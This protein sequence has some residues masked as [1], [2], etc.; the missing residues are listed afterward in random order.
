MFAVKTRSHS[1][2]LL[3]KL[4]CKKKSLCCILTT[5]IRFTLL[6]SFSKSGVS[7]FKR[8]N[9]T[10]TSFLKI[11]KKQCYKVLELATDA[12]SLEMAGKQ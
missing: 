2:Y 8:G 6:L 9:K 1:V 3:Y 10:I 5:K 12:N 7:N 4:T 11:L